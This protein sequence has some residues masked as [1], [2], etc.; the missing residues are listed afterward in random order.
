MVPFLK[1]ILNK[2]CFVSELAIKTTVYAKH[3]AS[4]KNSSQ[5]Q[6][7]SAKNNN[8]FLFF[9]IIPLKQVSRMT[10]QPKKCLDLFIKEKGC[11]S[12]YRF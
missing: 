3:I 11:F 9:Q 4:E 1:I 7:I 2:A 8:S 5:D 12:H 6:P 10:S